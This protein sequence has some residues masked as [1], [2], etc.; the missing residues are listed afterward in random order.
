MQ[1]RQLNQRKLGII[2]LR[3]QNKALLLKFLHKFY[4]K[5]NVPEADL[6]SILQKANSTTS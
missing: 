2:G 3:A 1:K 6:G 4:N 5:E